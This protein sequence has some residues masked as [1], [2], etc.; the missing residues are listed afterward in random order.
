MTWLPILAAGLTR[1]VKLAAGAQ[2]VAQEEERSPEVAEGVSFV[3][4]LGLGQEEIVDPANVPSGGPPEWFWLE[5]G[6]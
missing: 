6:R 5:G 4:G 2:A 3:I 1:P